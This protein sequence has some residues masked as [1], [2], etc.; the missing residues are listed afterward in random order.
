MRSPVGVVLPV[1]N[2]VL[3]VRSE[4]VSVLIAEP[5]VL[6][7]LVMVIVVAIIMMIGAMTVVMVRAVALPERGTS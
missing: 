3:V 4:V 6:S 1:L 5:E 2:V 7:V